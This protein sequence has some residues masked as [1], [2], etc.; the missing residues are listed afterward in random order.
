MNPRA[1]M[2]VTAGGMAIAPCADPGGAAAVT[3]VVEA[4]ARSSCAGARARST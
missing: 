4:A 1:T 3:R 2:I